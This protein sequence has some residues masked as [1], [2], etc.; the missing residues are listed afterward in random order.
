MI[1]DKS[2]LLSL[3]FLLP[4]LKIPSEKKKHKINLCP[5][6]AWPGSAVLSHSPKP[7]SSNFLFFSL[8]LSGGRIAFGWLHRKCPV[9][10]RPRF[11]CLW[12]FSY[13][14]ISLFLGRNSRRSGVE[15]RKKKREPK[16]DEA[17]ATT[18]VFVLRCVV[19]CVSHANSHKCCA[20]LMHDAEPEGGE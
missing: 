17:A 14:F 10:G 2:L 3:L 18:A 15:V 9:P 7:N 8:F 12:A 13:P 19:L 1:A 16:R 11:I 5:R 6:P 20:K 4:W